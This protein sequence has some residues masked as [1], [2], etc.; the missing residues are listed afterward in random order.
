M[1]IKN[2]CK[3]PHIKDLQA[4]PSIANF[5]CRTCTCRCWGSI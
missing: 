4:K 1:H 2:R 3:I 5:H